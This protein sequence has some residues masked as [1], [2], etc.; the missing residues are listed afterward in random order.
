METIITMEEY[1]VRDLRIL[2]VS[3]TKEEEIQEESAELRC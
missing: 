2:E 3:A 1:T